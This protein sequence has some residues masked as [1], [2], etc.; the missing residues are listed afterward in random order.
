LE[1]S[2]LLFL[3]VSWLFGASARSSSSSIVPSHRSFFGRGLMPAFNP[4]RG[5]IVPAPVFHFKGVDMSKRFFLNSL[6]VLFVVL[7]LLCLPCLGWS[8]SEPS[9]S[10]LFPTWGPFWWSASDTVI[11]QAVSNLGSIFSMFLGALCSSFLCWGF[12]RG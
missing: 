6:A 1:P 4:G 2:V 7:F 12:G 8:A 9:S 11:V 10:R 3:Q 5:R